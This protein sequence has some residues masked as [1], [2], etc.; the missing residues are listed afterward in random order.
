MFS[1]IALF[2]FPDRYFGILNGVLSIMVGSFC[3]LQ[4]GIFHW[5]ES[6]DNG[7]QHVSYDDN[8]LQF[9]NLCRMYIDVYCF[10]SFLT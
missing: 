6:Y 8:L 10:H 4:Y 3:F 5:Q 9:Y 1:A 2:R 7:A